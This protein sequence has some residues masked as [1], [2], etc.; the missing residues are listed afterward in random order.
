[1]EGDDIFR[2]LDMDDHVVHE[3]AGPWP[4]PRKVLGAR[5]NFSWGF[6]LV[7]GSDIHACKN[8]HTKTFWV[9]IRWH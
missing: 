5:G 4:A 2:S 6:S 7:S 3:G 8:T 1:M 9:L